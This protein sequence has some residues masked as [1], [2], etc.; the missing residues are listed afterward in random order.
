[1]DKV[2]AAFDSFDIDHS[3]KID[4]DEA[5]KHWSV[6]KFSFGKQSAIAFFKA[7]DINGKGQIDFEDFC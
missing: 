2:H 7:V 4:M 5:I 1:M 3:S 6:N